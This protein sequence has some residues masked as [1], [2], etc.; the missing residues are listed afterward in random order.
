MAANPRACASCAKVE[1]TVTQ[2]MGDNGTM[3]ETVLYNCHA[4]PPFAG[5]LFPDVAPTDWCRQF[6]A[7]STLDPLI[8]VTIR[9]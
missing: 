4:N 3:G 9:V 7:A 8:T 5:R 1:K 6:Q 2:T